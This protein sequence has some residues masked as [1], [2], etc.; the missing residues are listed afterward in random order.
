MAT[1]RT[2]EE[3]FLGIKETTRPKYKTTSM[4]FKEWVNISDELESC[5]PTEDEVTEF[6]K[7]LREEVGMDSSSMWT[8]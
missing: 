8:L 1:I 7:Y 5:K 4:M 6:L 3:A 2:D